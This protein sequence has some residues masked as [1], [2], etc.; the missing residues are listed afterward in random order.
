MA[1]I[2]TIARPYAEAVFKLAMAENSLGNWADILSKMSLIADNPDMR[3]AIA[4]PKLA[5]E[6]LAAL[7]FSVM[8]GSVNEQAKNFIRVLIENDRLNLLPEISLQFHDL[9][10]RQ[11]GVAEAEIISA[12]PMSDDEL[13]ALTVTLEKYFKRK[14][15]PSVHIDKELIGGVKVTIGDEVLDASLKTR[16]QSMATTLQS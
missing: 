14:I 11:E 9:K 8:N 13:N 6:T 5:G 2:T 10:D 12:F 3:A 15:K 1:E 7:F 16:L 4:D